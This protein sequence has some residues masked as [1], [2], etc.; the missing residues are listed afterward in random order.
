MKNWEDNSICG[1]KNRFEASIS[2]KGII[3]V[4][5]VISLII[6]SNLISKEDHHM[7]K[8]PGAIL[9]YPVFCLNY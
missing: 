8:V 1:V 4:S 9:V 7:V 2:K 3:Y 6:T 5:S